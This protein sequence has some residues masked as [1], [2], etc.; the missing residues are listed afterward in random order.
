MKPTKLTQW[1]SNILGNSGICTFCI[2]FLHDYI[3]VLWDYLASD[4]SG[5]E[6]RKS[7]ECDGGASFGW[8]RKSEL[9]TGA[10]GIRLPVGADGDKKEVDGWLCGA[11]GGRWNAVAGGGG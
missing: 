3:R 2:V 10:E 9:I 1:Q 5:L 6:D 11:D 7:K 4:C 8:D